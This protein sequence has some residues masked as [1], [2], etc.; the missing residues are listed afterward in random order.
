MQTRIAS[1]IPKWV[2]ENVSL[3][4]NGQNITNKDPHRKRDPFTLKLMGNGTNCL[5]VKAHDNF[6]QL[7]KAVGG[8]DQERKNGEKLM[9]ELGGNFP[10]QENGLK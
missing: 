1:T 3:V 10:A 6:M 2:P 9:V 8:Q 5:G 4:W 7:P